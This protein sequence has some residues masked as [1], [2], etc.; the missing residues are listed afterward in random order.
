M[1]RLARA[2]WL[3]VVV[4]NQ[5]GINRGLVTH[6][7]L[8]EIEDL[9]QDA[10]AAHGCRVQAFRYCPHGEDQRCL[11]RKPRPGLLVAAA[12]NL[13]LDLTRSWMIGDAPEDVICGRA[14]GC[15]TIRITKDLPRD[16]EAAA[17][18]LEAALI[19][20]SDGRPGQR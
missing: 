7:T 14:A 11:C 6:G 4:S 5:R 16:T 2:G 3:L 10:M 9:I 15:R 20:L 13:G 8:R 12:R 17:S 1:A 19:V 18:L